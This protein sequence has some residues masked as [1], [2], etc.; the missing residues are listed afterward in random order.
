MPRKARIDAPGALH[1]VIIRGIDRTHI[2]KGSKDYEQ[3][4]QRLGNILTETATPCL[5]WALLSN[6]A[7]L[8]LRTGRV[9]L[10]TVMGRLLSGYA[11]YFNR[12]HKR[13]GY[14]FQNRYKSFLCEIDPY[15]LEL[16]R[17][18]H[19]NPLRAGMVKDLRTLDTYPMTG[20]AAIMGRMRRD[21]QDVDSVLALFDHKAGP[22]RK[23]YR[24]FVAKGIPL[25]NR[26][27]L[28]GGGLVRSLGGWSAVKEL[29]GAET[30]I[31]SDERILGSSSF[32]NAVLKRADEVFTKKG[33]R[34]AG[35]MDMDRLIT[36]VAAHLGVDRVW[37]PSAM[38]QRDVAR[39]RAI[40]CYL[41]HH[42]LG[43]TGR[44]VAKTL[45]VTPSAVCRLAGRGYRDPVAKEIDRKIRSLVER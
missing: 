40:V 4:I 26:P 43:V 36:L 17:Y 33:R 45:G 18:V 31:A 27:D 28:V 15:L 41:A 12:R 24:A 10:S 37:I 5:A 44:Q 29:K 2:F 30:R 11:Q 35:G 16:V 3:F 25:G 13:H 1:H 39:A 22:A 42:Q 14:V 34:A 6:H 21:W 38:K 19:L 9:P 8:L 20:H 32:V 7:H 23:A